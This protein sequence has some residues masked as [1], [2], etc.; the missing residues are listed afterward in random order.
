MCVV[1]K[2][3]AKKKKIGRTNRM[4]GNNKYQ[5]YRNYYCNNSPFTIHVAKICVHQLICDNKHFIDLV[6]RI[7]FQQLSIVFE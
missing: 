6:F 3:I 7:Q 2:F 4:E 1:Y 5:I